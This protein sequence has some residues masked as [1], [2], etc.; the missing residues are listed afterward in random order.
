MEFIGGPIVFPITVAE[1][2]VNIIPL[3]LTW[4]LENQPNRRAS[5]AA[6]E[7]GSYRGGLQVVPV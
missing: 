1:K 4:F 3:D 7:S 5:F 2:E 6:W